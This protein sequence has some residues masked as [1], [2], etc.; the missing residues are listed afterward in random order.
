M[1]PFSFLTFYVQYHHGF[2]CPFDLIR[3]KTERKDIKEKHVHMGAAKLERTTIINQYW[4][5]GTKWST[6]SLKAESCGVVFLT[7]NNNNSTLKF[8]V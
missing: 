8:N 4:F 7:H 1:L 3:D 6:D 5:K 2:L